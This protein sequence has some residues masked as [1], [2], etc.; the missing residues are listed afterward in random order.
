MD[1]ATN[2]SPLWP[3][4]V[5]AGGVLGAVA[6]MVGASFFLGER[7]NDRATNEPYEGGT[8]PVGSARMRLS[9]KFYLVAMA[10]VIF[11]LE[12]VFVFGWASA[13][14]KTG[15]TGYIGLLV[16]LAVLVAGLIYEWKIG[17]LEWASS[18]RRQQQFLRGK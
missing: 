6:F 7:H 2:S 1:F 17:A 12:A 15:W 10:F 9:A 18:A 14:R 8:L 11:D 3:F 16:F 4:L 5:Y 13:F